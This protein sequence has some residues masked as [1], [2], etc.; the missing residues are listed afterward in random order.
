MSKYV[1]QYRWRYWQFNHSMC[2]SLHVSAKKDRQR[3]TQVKNFDLSQVKSNVKIKLTCKNIWNEVNV[4]N[5]E[6]K[7][8]QLVKMLD[9][10]TIFSKGGIVLWCFQSTSQLLTTSVNALIQNVILQV[11]CFL[12]LI[13]MLPI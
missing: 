6:S 4:A 11:T 9:L 7:K 1:K 13:N 10:F 5:F 3:D 8:L 2:I 12:K